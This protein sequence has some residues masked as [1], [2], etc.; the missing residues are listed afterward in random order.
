MNEHLPIPSAADALKLAMPIS[1]EQIQEHEVPPGIGWYWE[2]S[3]AKG[4]GRDCWRVIDG[5]LKILPIYRAYQHN[6]NSE[7]LEQQAIIYKRLVGKLIHVT[8][9]GHDCTVNDVTGKVVCSTRPDL[10]VM[11]VTRA[12]IKAFPLHLDTDQIPDWWGESLT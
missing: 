5:Q 8:A 4:V 7:I 9:G 3:S 10:P 12:R 6:P 1:Y 2:G 11:L